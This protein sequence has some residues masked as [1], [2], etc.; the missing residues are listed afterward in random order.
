MRKLTIFAQYK[1][2]RRRTV[3]WLWMK[4][5]TGQWRDT[6][7]P[8]AE[9]SDQAK[10]FL[11]GDVPAAPPVIMVRSNQDFLGIAAELAER[12]VNRG[13]DAHQVAAD[14]QARLNVS[15][16]VDDVRA[17]GAQVFVTVTWEGEG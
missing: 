1:P 8:W 17:A 3:R 2:V 5:V 10:A 12:V 11:R 9:F 16:L 4:R 6:T 7:T 13:E 15:A 14:I